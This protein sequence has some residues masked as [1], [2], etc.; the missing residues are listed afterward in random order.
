MKIQIRRVAKGREKWADQAAQSYLQ[1]PEI[2]QQKSKACGC[3]SS[4]I[5]NENA[6]KKLS[7]PCTGLEATTVLWP[8]MSGRV[9]D[10]RGAPRLGSRVH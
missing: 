3:L 5:L 7:E 8:W 9:V 6:L 2:F 1:R 4:V 10:H